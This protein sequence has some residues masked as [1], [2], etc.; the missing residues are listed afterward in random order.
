MVVVLVVE[1]VVEGSA[2]VVGGASVA[3][4]E[5]SAIS[6]E[7]PAEVHA[8][9]PT[10]VDSRNP[11]RGKRLTSSRLGEEELHVPFIAFDLSLKT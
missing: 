9:S 2:M 4:T 10:A 8:L 7:S 1:V 3:A 6:I 11:T 5:D